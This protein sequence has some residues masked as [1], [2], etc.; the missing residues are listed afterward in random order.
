MGHMFFNLRKTLTCIHIVED[1]FNCV[2]GWKF[3][4][5]TCGRAALFLAFRH[6]L[7]CFCWGPYMV[8]YETVLRIIFS[9]WI[10]SVLQDGGKKMRIFNQKICF[11]CPF[12]PFLSM[13][14]GW[15]API[16]SSLSYLGSFFCWVAGIIFSG[17]SL[18]Q[19]RVTQIRK[20]VFS[21]VVRWNRSSQ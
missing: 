13:T 16:L 17:F 18:R 4:S 9:N 19:S 3:L 11:R 20:L 5:M 15:I 10:I 6:S 14:S 21:C 2:V 1:I 8:F 12:K 7:P